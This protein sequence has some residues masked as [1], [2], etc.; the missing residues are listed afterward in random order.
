MKKGA[1]TILAI[2]LFAVSMFAQSPAVINYNNAKFAPA[3]R[4]DCPEI[5][6]YQ[7]LL[8]SLRNEDYTIYAN[9][10]KEKIELVSFKESP[11]DKFQ[12]TQAILTIENPLYETNNL[13]NYISTWIKS[14]YK[15]WGKNLKIEKEKGNLVSSASINIASHSRFMHLNKVFISP[16]LIIQTNNKDKL[17][18][19]MMNLMYKNSEYIGSDKKPTTFAAKVSDVYPF[20]SKGGYRIT[21]AKAYVSTYQYFWSFISDLCNELNTN[22]T[23]DPK[24][25]TKLHYDYSRDSLRAKYGEPTKV[26]ADQTSTPDINKELHFYETAQKFVFMGKTIDFQDIMSCE[27]VDDPQYIPG[28]STTLGAG[29]CIF[30]FGLGGAETVRTPDKTIHNYVVNVKIDNLGTPLI[31]IGTGQ[32]EYKAAEIA[33]TFEYILRHQQGN[34]VTG[35]TNQ[36]VASRNRKK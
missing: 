24:M 4:W 11:S 29:L 16:S 20:T 19:T 5:E 33:S 15:D 8:N 18:V 6:K 7:S 3:M 21:Y 23:K 12:V 22:F 28:R 27:I 34:K 31:R 17:L 14:K 9:N 32:N 1:I 10:V 35:T 13:L 26:I 30:G 36:K 25:L 2:T